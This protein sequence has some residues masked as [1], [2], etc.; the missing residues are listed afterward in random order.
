[1]KNYMLRILNLGILFMTVGVLVS[2]SSNDRTTE[3]GLTY[4]VLREGT[5]EV[6]K[7]KEYLLLNMKYTDEK[8]S[9]WMDTGVDN[10]PTMIK[11]Q[12][13]PK[14]IEA[15]LQDIFYDLKLGDSI[16]FE[17]SAYDLFKKTW[18]RP[19][20]EG[21]DSSQMITFLVGVEAILSEEEMRTWTQRKQEKMMGQQHDFDVKVIEEYLDENDIEAV[22]TGTGL[23]IEYIDQKEGA[24]PTEGQTVAV[25]YSGYNLEGQ[26]FDTSIKE[27]AQENGLYNE[28]R[29]PYEPIEFPLGTGRVIKGWDEGI[30]LLTVGSTARLYIPST[31]AYGGRAMSDVIKENAILIFDVELVE[32]K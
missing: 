28:Q 27:I 13:P 18:R 16:K 8:D 21:V 32:I 22:P 19:V 20:V 4:T 25:N 3:S 2:C 26:Y 1:M 23:Y 11:K 14:S 7:E 31:L 30:A 15:G 6:V 9:V 17:V 10:L 12:T 29:E 24:S 5:G